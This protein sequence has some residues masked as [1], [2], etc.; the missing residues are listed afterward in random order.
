MSEAALYDVVAATL[1]YARLR[2]ELRDDAKP[3]KDKRITRALY[4]EKKKLANTREKLAELLGISIQRL[5]T[6]EKA[7][8]K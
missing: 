5:R 8:L 1:G 2:N 4:F 6:W 3:R 7:H